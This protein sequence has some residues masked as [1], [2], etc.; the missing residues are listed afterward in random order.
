MPLFKKKISKEDYVSLLLTINRVTAQ[1][2]MEALKTDFGY[3]GEVENLEY[4]VGIFSLWI[5]ILSLPPSKYEFRDLIHE[6]IFRKMEPK[7]RDTFANEFDRRYK[8][9]FEA[10]NMWQKNPVGG[11]TLGAVI[12]ETIINQNPDFSLKEY[13][14]SVGA[15]KAFQ[16]FTLFA[17]T[18]KSTIKLLGE[19][20]KKYKITV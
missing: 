12:I 18:F 13:L 14:P 15:I 2:L 9:Y 10:Y 1:S 6:E 17:E 20:G 3:S 11:Q 16:A 4:E 7:Y 5:L 19:L 8:N